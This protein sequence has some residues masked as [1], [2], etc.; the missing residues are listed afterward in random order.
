MSYNEIAR[1]LGFSERQ[2]RGKI[3][4][5][6]LTKRIKKDSTLFSIIDNSDIAY[7]LGFIYADGYISENSEGKSCVLGIEIQQSDK[8]HLVKF[9]ELTNFDIKITDRT[10]DI[11]FNGYDYTTNISSMR[12]YSKDIVENLK[13]LSIEIDLE[14]LPF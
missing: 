13:K 4:N 9:K 7:W 10:R 12:I 3:N 11:S 2:I 14:R 1:N 5:M 6:G 8:E